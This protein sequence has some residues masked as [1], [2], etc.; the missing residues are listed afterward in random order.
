MDWEVVLITK[1]EMLHTLD[2]HSFIV[3]VAST[4][5]IDD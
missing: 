4:E 3:D 2:Y 1:E 5:S